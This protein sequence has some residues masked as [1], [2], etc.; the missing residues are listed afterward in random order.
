MYTHILDICIHTYLYTHTCMYTQ[1]HT[2]LH[3]LYKHVCIAVNL[4]RTYIVSSVTVLYLCRCQIIKA[5]AA[6]YIC[7]RRS[8]AIWGRSHLAFFS[9]CQ[10]CCAEND[11]LLGLLGGFCRIANTLRHQQP[12]GRW[13]L[14][15][16]Y[17][18]H[19]D[20][21]LVIDWIVFVYCSWQACMHGWL[22]NS[23]TSAHECVQ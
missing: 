1:T 8:S 5:S 15:N 3:Y 22:P 23:A 13:C 18:W 4:R 6:L 16:Q 2:R 21:M 19:T 7:P 20:G 11:L 10:F 9:L 12:R 14:A 17:G